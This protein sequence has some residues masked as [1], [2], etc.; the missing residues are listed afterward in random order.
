MRITLTFISPELLQVVY[1]NRVLKDG[2]PTSGF[3]EQL[4]NMLNKVAAREELLFLLTVSTDNNSI[5]PIRHT[6]KLPVDEIVLNNSENLQVPHSHDD[7]NLAA[8]HRHGIRC[9]IWLS[10]PFPLPSP[11]TAN[12]SGF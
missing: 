8:I 6:I 10:L 9:R 5:N 2:Y 11:K 1:I 3:Q 12:A 4:Q 7:Y